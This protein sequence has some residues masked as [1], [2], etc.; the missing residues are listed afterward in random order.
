MN[1]YESDKSV[2][3]PLSLCEYASFSLFNS[4]CNVKEK[5]KLTNAIKDQYCRQG[6]L[7]IYKS[8]DFFPVLRRDKNW[9]LYKNSEIDRKKLWK[10]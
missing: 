8:S 10:E 6:I 4:S 1:S 2:C 5:V 3:V 7:H 9:V